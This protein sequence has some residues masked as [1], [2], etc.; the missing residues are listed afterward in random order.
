MV[1]SRR[2]SIAASATQDGS[3]KE[4]KDAPLF[5]KREQLLLVL[6]M[7]AQG[8]NWSK[9]SEALTPHLEPQRPSDLFSTQN[10]QSRFE[11]L[12]NT[13]VLSKRKRPGSRHAS[14]QHDDADE[15]K[16]NLVRM[17]RKLHQ[18]R[19][20]ELKGLMRQD[21]ALYKRLKEERQGI[22]DGK[23]DHLLEP[24]TTAYQSKDLTHKHLQDD[25]N[26]AL[27]PKVVS[28]P[29]SRPGL[30]KISVGA[31]NAE[32]EPEQEEENE[33]GGR[34]T[35]L[36][37]RTEDTEALAPKTNGLD[38]QHSEKPA[39]TAK[40]EDQKAAASD[41]G[42][43]NVEE[44]DEALAPKPTRK[45][46]S[47]GASP[48]KNA[49]QT[50]EKVSVQDEEEEAEEPRTARGRR[51]VP[52]RNRDKTESP[53]AAKRTAAPEEK[54]DEKEEPDQPAEEEAE[55]ENGDNDVEEEEGE[56]DHHMS[57]VAWRK[58]MVNVFSD[59]N[60]QRTAPY[61]RTK[62][63][64]VNAGEYSAMI[65]RPIYIKDL[66]QRV[67]GELIS[68]TEEFY[69]DCLQIVANA[70]MFHNPD[71]EHAEMAEEMAGAMSS[72]VEEFLE[73]ERAIS[74]KAQ[75]SEEVPHLRKA[76]SRN[77][78][79]ADEGPPTRRQKRKISGSEDSAAA[80]TKRPKRQ[81]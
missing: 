75:E 39:E 19:M 36:R 9:V 78:M 38:E 44:K 28:Q 40:E 12:Q 20:S 22:Q 58:G 32:K 80:D 66:K 23:L 21:R 54:L 43:E 8:N 45:S 3:A 65:Y 34:R 51:R 61:F 57:A 48:V 67:Q 52:S 63:N 62:A 71:S 2:G 4:S 31:R 5:T 81:R 79:N 6:A 25:I 46:P 11:D 69:R 10:V 72:K 64:G 60:N 17:R 33:T 76:L 50:E 49:P 47:R 68:T 42:K 14:S 7:Q 37:S 13:T 30:M 15:L 29:G 55:Q 26:A 35:R 74:G 16:Q 18:E 24:L 1:R 53:A 56:E 27:K 73:T 41:E 77:Q 59:I 70:V